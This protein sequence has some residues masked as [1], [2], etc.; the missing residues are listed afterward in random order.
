MPERTARA[1][2]EEAD[3][4]SGVR[5]RLHL[6]YRD[7]NGRDLFYEEMDMRPGEYVETPPTRFAVKMTTPTGAEVD[8]DFEGVLTITPEV[9]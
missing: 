5:V 1:E 9:L 2:G 6:V 4:A 3:L 8:H 7:L